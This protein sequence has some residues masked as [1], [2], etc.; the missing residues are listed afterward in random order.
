MNNP[1][2][3]TITE[4]ERWYAALCYFFSPF[5]PAVLLFILDLNDYPYLK[6]HIFQ[7]LVMGLFFLI[8][9]PFLLI[10]SLGVA[11]L[12]WLI[13]PYWSLLAFNGQSINIP[14]ISAW[15]KDQGWG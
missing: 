2:P 3:S 15:V 13:M 9:M 4:K 5:F 12:F 14:W 8:F 1:I 7:S 10:T 11:G 6:T